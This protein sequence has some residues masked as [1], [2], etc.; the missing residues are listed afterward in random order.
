MHRAMAGTVGALGARSRWSASPRQYSNTQAPSGRQQRVH[1]GERRVVERA[2][3][4]VQR[5]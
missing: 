5:E 2:C 1:R 3:G 4:S